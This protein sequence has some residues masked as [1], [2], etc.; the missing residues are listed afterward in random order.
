MKLKNRDRI[1]EIKEKLN[2]LI[3]QL[4]DDIAKKALEMDRFRIP[5]YGIPE[6]NMENPVNMFQ[7]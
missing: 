1:G 2:G 7:R 6:P 4:Y 5:V 3:N